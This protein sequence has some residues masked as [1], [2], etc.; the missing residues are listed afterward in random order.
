MPARN[1]SFSAKKHARTEGRKESV[2][3]GEHSN[4]ALRLRIETRCSDEFTFENLCS[5]VMRIE[6]EMNPFSMS[7]TPKLFRNRTMDFRRRRK[8]SS[9][10]GAK[11][12]FRRKQKRHFGAARQFPQSLKGGKIVLPPRRHVSPCSRSSL[13][14]CHNE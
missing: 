8:V 7:K 4:G 10:R 1:S 14:G 13:S 9:G 5:L 3:E 6:L 12:F 2:N 11:V